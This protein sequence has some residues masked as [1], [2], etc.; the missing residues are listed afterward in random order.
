[1]VL[2]GRE[3]RSFVTHRGSAALFCREDIDVPLL[4]ESSHI[5]VGKCSGAAG[6]TPTQQRDALPP[7]ALRRAGN[8]TTLFGVRWARNAR[9]LL[10]RV[11][12][13]EASALCAASR[14]LPCLP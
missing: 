8:V 2:S 14:A 13:A 4:L 12:P 3:D 11:H 5:H 10:L 7:R 1:M 9:D 6:S